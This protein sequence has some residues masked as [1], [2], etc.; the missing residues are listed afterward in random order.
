M[1]DFGEK[2]REISP[3]EVA[4]GRFWNEFDE[5]TK[6]VRMKILSLQD[7]QK[8]DQYFRRIDDKIRQAASS[9]T[10]PS[11]YLSYHRALAGGTSFAK[12]PK[13]DFEGENSLTQFYRDLLEEL[14]SIS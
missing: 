13:T 11:E 12:S 3:Q 14:N 7:T 1:E 5:L 4:W 2:N 6:S 10:N 8:R 9:V